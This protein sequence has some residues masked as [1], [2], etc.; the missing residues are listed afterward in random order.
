MYDVSIAEW[1]WMTLA[2]CYNVHF[3][4]CRVEV[5]SISFKQFLQSWDRCFSWLMKY[6]DCFSGY[7]CCCSLMLSI[8][9]GLLLGDQTTSIVTQGHPVSVTPLTQGH[10]V[11]VAPLSQSLPWLKDTLSQWHPWPLTQGHPVPVAPLT[12]WHP[13]LSHSPDSV[14][15]RTQWNML[16]TII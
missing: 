16:S 7:R 9:L 13:R 10:P 12:Q 1:K 11:S 3:M 8:G 15:T 5:S 4:T 6:I 14:T 2:F